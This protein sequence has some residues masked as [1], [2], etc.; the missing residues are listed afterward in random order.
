MMNDCDIIRPNYIKINR[1]RWAG[2][3]ARMDDKEITKSILNSNPGGQRG[4]G[5]PKLRWI[6]GV[7][8]DLRKVGCKSWKMVAQDR[9]RWRHLLEEARAHPGL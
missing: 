1:L 2:H 9:R 8:H 7:E 4:R 5:R 3:V 6:D